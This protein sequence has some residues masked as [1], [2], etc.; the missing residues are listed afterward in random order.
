MSEAA[1]DVP[2]DVPGDVP[3]VVPGDAVDH[4]ALRSAIEF[5]VLI[6]EETQKRKPPMAIPSDLRRFFGVKRIPTGALGKLRR[7]IE[8]DD[9]FRTRL[10]AAATPELVDDVGR[11]WLQRPENWEIDIVELVSRQTADAVDADAAVAL[12]KAERRR[13]AAEEAA[14]RARAEVV[15][16]TVTLDDQRAELAASA[17]S[18]ASAE[19]ALAAV[20]AEVDTLRREARHASDREA[21]TRAKLESLRQQVDV[22]RSGVAPA[23][24]TAPRQLVTD[25]ELAGLVTLANRTSEAA[26]ELA[27]ELAR[28]MSPDGATGAN[29]TTDTAQ[30]ARQLPRRR[31]LKLPG[32]VLKSSAAAARALLQSDAAVL[33][34]GYNVAMLGWP[35][36]TLIEQRTALLDAV[37]S[38]VHRF[39]SDVTVVFD[40]DDVVGAHAARRQAFRVIYSPTGVTADDLIRSE[41]S[42]L[43]A[44]RHVV[45]VTN[46]AAIVSD[47]R[48]AG[49]N[50][51]ASNALLAI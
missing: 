6:A 26:G 27:R 43:P 44:Q 20:R 38:L 28:K 35:R 24:D 40:G 47:V 10:G 3:R 14:T 46:D 32:G 2:G 29:D 16:L 37:E 8:A 36:L 5:A 1:D 11:L 12:R 19:A 13:V 50:V 48:A 17:N 31:P 21:A 4:R 49:A 18:L 7:T 51:L 23:V 22:L 45:V 25:E 34:D 9:V 30:A 33:V 42:R 15:R 41:V 39:G